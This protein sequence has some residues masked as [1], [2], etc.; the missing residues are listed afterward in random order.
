MTVAVRTELLALHDNGGCGR[1]VAALAIFL[2]DFF[3][4]LA[5]M[6]QIGDRLGHGCEDVPCAFFGL[7]GDFGD[8]IVGCVA[9]VAR[10]IGMDRAFVRY[11]HLSL[12]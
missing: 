3:R 10:Q 12:Y 5:G 2:S 9:L 8:E 1:T 6:D 11:V 4:L 7:E